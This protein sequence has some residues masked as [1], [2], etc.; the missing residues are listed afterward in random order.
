MRFDGIGNLA[1]FLG[2]LVGAVIGVVILL[3]DS[4]SFPKISIGLYSGS[5]TL[6]S[7]QEPILAQV[8]QEASFNQFTYSTVRA[9]PTSKSSV[10]LVV[11]NSKFAFTDS[12]LPVQI[13]YNQKDLLLTGKLSSKGIYSGELLDINRNIV[14]SWSLILIS[15]THNLDFTISQNIKAAASVVYVDRITTDKLEKL[16][17]ESTQLDK[18]LNRATS[19]LDNLATLS[20]EGAEKLKSSRLDREYS[21]RA[22]KESQAILDRLHDQIVITQRVSPQRRLYELSLESLRLEKQWFLQKLGHKNE[23]TK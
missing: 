23:Q 6:G 8:A 4:Q 13:S 2:S 7:K 12:Y 19:L 11:N 21:N 3:L 10:P 18:D 20:L 15:E 22:L 5:I 16:Q 14:G 1:L 9:D 17:K